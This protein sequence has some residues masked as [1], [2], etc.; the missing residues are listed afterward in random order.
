MVK[1]AVFV[2]GMSFIGAL[3]CVR[4]DVAD[5]AEPADAAPVDPHVVVIDPAY[6]ADPSQPG[7]LALGERLELIDLPTSGGARLVL[8]EAR[9][10]GPI[11]LLWFGGAEHAE[12]SAW[13]GEL[14]K[15]L[16]EFESRGATLVIVR[17]LPPER[18][19]A[20]ASELG[21]QAVVAAD[22][23][24]ALAR[25]AGLVEPLPEWALLIVDREGVLRYRK[26]AG[27]RPELEELLGVLDAAPPRCC[28]DA[29]EAPVCE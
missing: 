5:L 14:A 15:A 16:V 9:A 1:P 7:L 20:F 29:C 24:G 18:A 25:S 27:R 4:A 6:G 23:A 10:A 19:D 2:L 22:E 12:L 26:L 17:P 11:V 8:A 21:L 28:I 13:V 3:A